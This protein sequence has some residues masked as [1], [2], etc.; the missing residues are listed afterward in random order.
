MKDRNPEVPE[1]T[2]ISDNQELKFAL[3]TA[4]ETCCQALPEDEKMQ[5]R[6]TRS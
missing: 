5:D 4:Q 6:K 3:Y 1:K 2:H